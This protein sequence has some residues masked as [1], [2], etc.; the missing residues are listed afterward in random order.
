MQEKGETARQK[1]KQEMGETDKQKDKH[2][3]RDKQG[4]QE[5]GKK[6]KRERETGIQTDKQKERERET[7]RE[8]HLIS[9]FLHLKALYTKSN[10]EHKVCAAKTDRV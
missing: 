9:R 10:R 6:R 1:E 5:T 2:M 7:G 4:E 8:S 3:K